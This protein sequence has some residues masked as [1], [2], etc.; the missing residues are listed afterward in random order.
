MRDVSVSLAH[1]IITTVTSSTASLVQNLPAMSWLL[2]WCLVVLLTTLSSNTIMASS[3]SS[4][5]SS[6]S[7]TKTWTADGLSQTDLMLQDSV[8]VLDNADNIIGSAS[9]QDAHI[10]RDD[11]PYG[12]L[13]RA[14]SVFLFDQS[15]GKLLLQRRASHKITFPNVWTNTCCS[16]PLHSM[17]PS[18]V[19]TAS[20]VADGSVHGVKHAALRKLQQELGIS[21][22]AL[23]LS[24]FHFVTRLHYWAADTVTHGT[25]SPWGEHEIDYVLLASVKDAESVVRVQAN[26]DEVSDYK[27]VSIT[28]LQSMLQDKSL[29]FSPWF[30]L[31]CERWMF[32]SWW[33]DLSGAMAGK[34]D[35]FSSIH[36]FDPPIE[37]FG[38]AGNARAM[39][40]Q[41]TQVKGDARYEI[42]A[43]A[44]VYFVVAGGRLYEY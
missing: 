8:L 29:L 35:D 34:Y 3:S 13:H 31:I 6:T 18:E 10:F 12:V 37:H 26:P 25:K 36:E 14:F 24:D 28:E 30:R 17:Q 27:W 39:F 4:A 9:K 7:V 2:L 40:A 38:G 22:P 42:K 19:D 11:Q 16:H 43:A 15:T 20:N 23:Q 32:T 1:H 44:E 41:V 5:S 33:A 21:P